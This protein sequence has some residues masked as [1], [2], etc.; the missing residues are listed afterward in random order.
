MAIEIGKWDTIIVGAG[1]AGCVLAARLSADPERRVLLLEAGPSDFNLM[2]RVPAH[3]FRII[4]DPRYDWCLST[5][6]EPNMMDRRLSWP[7]GKVLGG[8]SA[9]NG[10]LAIRGQPED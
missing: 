6:P 9:I 4:G 1:S 8:S 10:L 2:L 7:R 5:E 3:N